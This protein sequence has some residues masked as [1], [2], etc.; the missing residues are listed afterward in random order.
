[1]LLIT[2]GHC[3]TNAMRHEARRAL[4]AETEASHQ[5]VRGDAFLARGVQTEANAHCEAEYGATS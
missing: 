5:L 1:M 3:F 2:I 4:G